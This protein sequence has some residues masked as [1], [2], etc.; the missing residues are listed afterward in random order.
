MA[1]NKRTTFVGNRL[2]ERYRDDVR[3]KFPHCWAAVE[4][5]ELMDCYSNW[6]LVDFLRNIEPKTR[7]DSKAETGLVLV[8]FSNV[9]ETAYGLTREVLLV[10]NS[11]SDLQMRTYESLPVFLEYVAKV[12]GRQVT[13][14]LVLV[15]TSDPREVEKLDEWSR[16]RP[17]LA[18]PA[19]QLVLSSRQNSDTLSDRLRLRIYRRN[20]YRQTSPV[21]SSEFYG[22]E[23]SLQR[24]RDALD[25][26]SPLMILGLRKSGKTS[27]MKESGRRYRSSVHHFIYADLER[28][29]APPDRSIP[30]LL[31]DLVDQ[32]SDSLADA[33]IEPI[34]LDDS[35]CQTSIGLFRRNLRRLLDRHTPDDF[36]LVIALDEI[37]HLCPPR[38]LQRADCAELTEITQFFAAL[39]SLA[40]ETTKFTFLMAGLSPALLDQQ[41]LFGQHN[42]VFQWAS[43]LWV[44]PFELAE[45]S[46]LL[47]TLGKRM[48]LQ[49]M[50]DGIHEAVQLSGGH[51]FLLRQLAAVV[52]DDV[53]LDARSRRIHRDRVM[54]AQGSWILETRALMQET[55]NHLERYYPFELKLLRQLFELAKNGPIAMGPRLRMSN[56]FRNLEGLGL[57]RL[58]S[59][60]S[61]VET[62]A[63]LRFVLA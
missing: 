53:D 18:I 9:L 11:L 14:N 51:A 56:A 55:L 17:I 8:R 31:G 28:L 63:F 35:E 60:Q 37:E 34:G 19:G 26:R 2:A 7:S 24:I 45:S 12:A 21:E 43:R 15:S 33:G 5:L 4:A 41:M 44:S 61:E 57:V 54:R 13:P 30:E 32:I 6:A 49:W 25:T 59:D 16:S 48:G 46:E 42:P 22:R 29:P 27:L 23:I 58:T 47:D 36:R 50:R 1:E 39:R 38:L 3:R 10:T 40:Q 62:A 20:T 52:A